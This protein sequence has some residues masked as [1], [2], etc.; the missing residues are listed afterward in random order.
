M[1]YHLASHHI[2]PS[3]WLHRLSPF[4]W[5]ARL[6]LTSKQFLYVTYVSH[7]MFA[8][9]TCML[10]KCAW[11]GP[12]LHARSCWAPKTWIEIDLAFAQNQ[13]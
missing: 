7:K 5:E 8:M 1:P 12:I 11:H 4:S 3:L 13:F 2:T 9:R 6:L 10:V